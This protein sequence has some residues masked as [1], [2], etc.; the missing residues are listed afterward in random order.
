[1]TEIK[2]GTDGIHQGLPLTQ[3]DRHYLIRSVVVNHCITGH[4]ISTSR[5]FS[6]TGLGDSGLCT[7]CR[8]TG[9]GP[10]GERLPSDL[11]SAVYTRFGQANDLAAC[12]GHAFLY[13]ELRDQDPDT[14][15]IFTL[16]RSV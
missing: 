9:T 3:P 14:V 8:R 10:G 7:S 5:L 16:G 6:P 11:E 13:G 2:Y 1:M 12:I 4:F 15:Y